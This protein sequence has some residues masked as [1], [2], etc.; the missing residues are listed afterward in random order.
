MAFGAAAVPVL[1]DVGSAVSQFPI[2][3]GGFCYV[4]H[5][6]NAGGQDTDDSRSNPSLTRVE[7]RQESCSHTLRAR[8]NGA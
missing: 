1:K 2:A 3:H 7:G 8:A 5:E 6:G 4:N